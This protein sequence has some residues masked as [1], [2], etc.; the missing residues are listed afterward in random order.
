M[1][2]NLVGIGAQKAAT[3]WMHETL[4]DHPDVD[5]SAE[6]ELQFFSAKFDR[7]SIWYESNFADNAAKVR[8]E[9]SPSYLYEPEAPKRAHAYNP[10]LRLVAILRDPV[11][12]AFSNHLH[13]IRKSHIPQDTSFEVGLATNPSYRV[14]SKYAE[15]LARWLAVFPRDSLLILLAEDIS[16]DPLSAYKTI[17]EHADIE[18]VVTGPDQFARRHESTVYRNL[19]YGR[20]LRR[21]GDG[22]RSIG[23]DHWVTALKRAPGVNQLIEGNK[24]NL[25]SKVTEMRPETRA[26][27]E[28]EFQ[29]DMLQVAELIGRNTLPWHSFT[30]PGQAGDAA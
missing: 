21:M 26:M 2:V 19:G 1:K 11:E 10:E 30:R 8:T 4:R 20:M 24:E 9:T 16:N 6:K 13:E 25:R 23:L 29:Q 22:L 5:A 18:P 15:H 7:G 28:E 17:C 14:Q 3:S 12:R 27:L